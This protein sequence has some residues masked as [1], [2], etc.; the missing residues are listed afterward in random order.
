MK[1]VLVF[2]II[3]LYAGFL[4]AQ[5]RTEV[6]TTTTKTTMNGI[7]VD[8]AC[9]SSHSE[10]HES[11]TTTNPDQSVT[12]KTESS[13]SESMNCPVTTT[14]T[15]FGLITPEGR[16]IR[17]DEPSNTRVIEIVKGN[18][19]YARYLAER[20][21]LNVKVIGA[22]RGDVAIVE[23]IDPLTGAQ[24]VGESARV[25]EQPAGAPQG[26]MMFDVRWHDDQGKLLVT[27]NGMSFEDVS[28]AKHSRSWSYAQIKEFKRQGSN[29][30]K[31]EPYSGDSFEFHVGG[32]MI[33][34]AVYNMIAERIVAARAR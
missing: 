15:T 2:A 12:T 1:R 6:Q 26:D 5:T 11:S 19:A 9:Q 34:D 28:N 24:V 8:A 32:P 13:R 18:K 31:V 4:C 33:S 17:F 21:P 27:A 14:T 29:E 23:S 22:T 25:V 30:I 20:A 16:Y 10:H 3:P 7:L